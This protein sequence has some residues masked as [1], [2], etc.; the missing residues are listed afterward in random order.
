MNLALPLCSVFKIAEY[1]CHGMFDQETSL[2]TPH[3]TTCKHPTPGSPA[4]QH[5]NIQYPV[6]ALH[7]GSIKEHFDR[8][9]A[10]AKLYMYLIYRSRLHTTH[11][12]ISDL[13]QQKL[14]I[15]RT[16]VRYHLCHQLHPATLDTKALLRPAMAATV[17]YK[18]KMLKHSTDWKWTD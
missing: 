3:C 7:T 2:Q 16:G 14:L 9:S 18:L 11:S 8:S 15:Q 1:N 13:I 6:S 17:V 12:L 5:N 4:L 10:S